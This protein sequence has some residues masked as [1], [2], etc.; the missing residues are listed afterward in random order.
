MNLKRIFKV[1]T[2]EVFDFLGEGRTHAELFPVEFT[3][4][5]GSELIIAD[6]PESI[7]KTIGP[8]VWEWRFVGREWFWK[9]EKY[10]CQDGVERRVRR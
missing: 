1:L 6:L 8:L 2:V 10:P 7:K 3:A 4:I 5:K 9:T